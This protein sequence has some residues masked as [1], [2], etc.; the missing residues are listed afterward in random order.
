MDGLPARQ[1]LLLAHSWERERRE[2]PAT[3]PHYK[4]ELRV[5]LAGFLDS[6]QAELSGDTPPYLPVVQLLY[7]SADP[8][9]ITLNVYVTYTNITSS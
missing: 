5:D 8:G 1:S 6:A 3:P 7:S 4:G 9:Q 2:N